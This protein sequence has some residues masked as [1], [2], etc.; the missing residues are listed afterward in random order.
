[1]PLSRSKSSDSSGTSPMRFL[2]SMS[3]SGRRKP[4]ISISPESGGI[5]PVSM[6]MVVDFPAPLGPRKPKK[7]PARHFQIHAIHG[8]LQSITLPQAASNDGGAHRFIVAQA[9]TPAVPANR[10]GKD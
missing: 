5:S 2:I 6:R 4:R 9:T 3:C 7:E 8:R 10:A 1:M